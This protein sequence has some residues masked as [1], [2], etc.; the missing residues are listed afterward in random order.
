MKILEM[1]Q[2][3]LVIPFI[4]DLVQAVPES[5][6]H[7]A[8]EVV[9]KTLSYNELFDNID[10]FS[11]SGIKSYSA[12]LFDPTRYQVIVGAR[13]RIFRLSLT[14]LQLLGASDWSANKSTVATCTIKGQSAEACHNYI[15]L[16]HL[17]NGRVLVCGTN[18]FSP[19]CTWRRLSDIDHIEAW[20]KGVA[21][22]PFNP[23]H[24]VTSLMTTDGSLYVGTPTDFSGREN[25]FMRAMGPG[26]RLRTHQYDTKWLSEPTFVS[27]FEAGGFVYFVFRENAVESMNC[28]NQVYSRIG[29]VCKSD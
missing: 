5:P 23:V 20:E 28:R 7:G 14:G 10:R 18:A 11:I 3:L 24:S 1:L 15:K 4:T 27:S 22:S 17:N 6:G 19:I 25:A 29:R 21:R 9:A 8:H 26:E 2:A 16:L 12:L 13:D